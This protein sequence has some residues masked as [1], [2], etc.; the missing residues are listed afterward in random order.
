MRPRSGA[1]AAV[2]ALL[3]LSGCSG[4]DESAGAGPSPGR[5]SASASPST[6]A[7]EALVDELLAGEEAPAP[8][9]TARGELPLVTGTSAPVEVEVLQVRASGESTLLRWR[10]RSSDGR[11]RPLAS[12]ALST[13]PSRDTR[14][15]A[16]VDEQGGVRL[17]PYTY[18]QQS[19]GALSC[20]CSTLPGRVGST[21][22]YLYALF[23]P[24]GAGVETVDVVLPGVL[25]AEDVEVTR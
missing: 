7:A 15:V 1:P 4:D 6:S 23:P 19:S 2:A 16:L 17:Q 3:L 11:S 9:V 25:T 21:G 18:E 22:T 13:S 10:L 24:L 20:V 5:A 12:N 14:L 8:L